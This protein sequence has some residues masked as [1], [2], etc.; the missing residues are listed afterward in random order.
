MSSAPLPLIYRLFHSF[1]VVIHS[2]NIYAGTPVEPY[3]ITVHANRCILNNLCGNCIKVALRLPLHA[4]KP[5]VRSVPRHHGRGLHGSGDPVLET[6]G[7]LR[8]EQRLERVAARESDE[9]AHVDQAGVSA[10]ERL[11][12]GAE[13]RNRSG[14]AHVARR[15]PVRLEKRG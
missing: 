10:D 12:G 4:G 2:L 9:F 6:P 7:L 13:E 3:L 1:Q 11:A 15:K 5:R 8:R 14:R